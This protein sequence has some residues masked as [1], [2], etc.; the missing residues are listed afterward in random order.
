MDLNKE[1]ERH[2]CSIDSNNPFGL[3][4]N[5][6]PAFDLN[7]EPQSHNPFI[8]KRIPAVFHY[9]IA[10]IQDVKGEGNGGFRAVALCLG[11]I[12]EQWI[13]IRQQLL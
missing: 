11:H 10:G 3:D 9:Y 1:P 7:D 12:E 8:M 6:E 5:K 13:N 4:L 2:G